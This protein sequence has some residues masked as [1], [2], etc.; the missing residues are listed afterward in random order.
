VHRLRRTK[1]NKYFSEKQPSGQI[2][3]KSLL[4]K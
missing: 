1:N 4:R 3:P 2:F